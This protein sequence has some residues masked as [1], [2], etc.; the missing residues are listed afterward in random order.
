MDYNHITS[1][2]DKFK[3]IISLSQRH[4]S[5]IAEMITKHISFQIKEEMIK[6]KGS[7]ITLEGSP[8][9]KSEVLMHKSRI[10][11]DISSLIPERKFTD[12]R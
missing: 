8:M 7:I 11:S 12:I 5:V 3:K 9:L 4:N 2:L 1:F 10:L 6:I